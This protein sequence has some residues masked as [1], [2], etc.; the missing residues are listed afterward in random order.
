MPDVQRTGG[1]PLPVISPA[2][3]GTRSRDI[4]SKGREIAGPTITGRCRFFVS[5]YKRGQQG[6]KKKEE[7]RK[8]KKR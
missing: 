5:L 6:K 8:K 1:W 3:A 7:K 4:L 2:I